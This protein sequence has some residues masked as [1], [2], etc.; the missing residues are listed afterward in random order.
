MTLTRRTLRSASAALCLAV[1]LATSAA[2]TPPAASE[3]RRSAALLPPSTLV[4]FEL[5]NLSRSRDRLAQCAL[6]RIRNEPAVDRFLREGFPLAESLRSRAAEA[7]GL[8]WAEFRE[9]FPGRVTLALLDAR[10]AEHETHYWLGLIA[11]VDPANQA[12]PRLRDAL[13][14]RYAERTG[15]QASETEV[16]AAAAKSLEAADGAL[17]LAATTAGRFV[18]VRGPERPHTTE[19]FSDLLSPKGPRLAQEETFRTV[20]ERSALPG[21][22]FYVYVNLTGLLEA[23]S[24]E[25][26]GPLKRAFEVTGLAGIQAAGLSVRIEPPGIRDQVY[27]LAPGPRRGL[28]AL[29]GPGGLDEEALLRYVPADAVSFSAGRTDLRAGYRLFWDLAEALV[30]SQ[31]ARARREVETFEADTGVSIAEDILGQL[32]PEMVNFKVLPRVGLTAGRS[33]T[34]FVLGVKDVERL[35]SALGRLKNHFQTPE[36]AAATGTFQVLWEERE[37]DGRTLTRVV[38]ANPL[39]PMEPSFTLYRDESASPPRDLLLVALRFQSLKNMISYISRPAGGPSVKD[40]RTN[41]DFADLRKRLPERVGNL[42]YSDLRR[43]FL[44]TYGRVAAWVSLAQG[45]RRETLFDPNLLP[46]AEV[47]AR[48]LFGLVTASTADSQGV[49]FQAYG[50]VG[51]STLAAGLGGGLVLALPRVVEAQR[52]EARRECQEHLRRLGV[53]LVLYAGEHEG[54]F[55]DSLEELRRVLLAREPGGKLP[56]DGRWFRCPGRPLSAEIGYEYVSGLGLD[57]PPQTIVCYDRKGNHRGGRNV[58]FVN[59]QVRWL[60]EDVFQQVMKVQAERLG[61]PA[62]P[63]P[64]GR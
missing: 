46:P 53:E 28:L 41:P 10:A 48:H 14:S 1:T 35:R 36:G 49:L 56:G 20:R 4:Y 45:V 6:G 7:L 32:G 38:I 52:A 13:L 9:A 8:S 31:A 58:L 33:D 30:G 39:Q 40:I 5:P 34:L 44:T 54:K 60:R 37:F 51:Y 61:G 16:A 42:S 59:G 50:P 21:E 47:I 43:Q 17:L 25:M 57:S 18:V 15:S 29:S 22:D 55:P 64:E 19:L 63:G 26:S 11:Q 3:A 23:L 27:L 12:F 24:P 62:S 2:A